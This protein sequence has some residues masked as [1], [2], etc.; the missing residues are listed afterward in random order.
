MVFFEND[1][2][3]IPFAIH[4]LLVSVCM[5]LAF[6]IFRTDDDFKSK[7]MRKFLYLLTLIT[8]SMNVCYYIHIGL[9]DI[10]RDMVHSFANIVLAICFIVINICIIKELKQ[11]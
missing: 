6:F 2:K 10:K 11:D 9:S 8:L 5:F 3:S 7:K 4:S 1:I